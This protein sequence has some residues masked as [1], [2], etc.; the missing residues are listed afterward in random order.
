MMIKYA[1]KIQIWGK[2]KNESSASHIVASVK[3][4]PDTTGHTQEMVLSLEGQ[5]AQMATKQI[6]NVEVEVLK[7]EFL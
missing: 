7:S 5:I 3:G 4:S 6:F 2:N 1:N